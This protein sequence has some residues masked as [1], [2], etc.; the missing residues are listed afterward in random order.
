MLIFPFGV[1][2]FIN[3]FWH[4]IVLDGLVESNNDHLREPFNGIVDWNNSI[5]YVILANPVGNLI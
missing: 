2:L 5:Y 3:S 1:A 4:T